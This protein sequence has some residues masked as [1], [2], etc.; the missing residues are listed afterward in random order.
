MKRTMLILPAAL[1]LFSALPQAAG[2]E[3]PKPLTVS[4]GE[5]I[6]I[7]YT[8]KLED[9]S[10]V[11]TNVGGMPLKYVQGGNELIPALELALEGLKVGDTKKVVLEPKDGYGEIDPKAFQ[12]V[13][14]SRIPPEALVVGT[15]L[16]GQDPTGDPIHVRVHEIKDSTVVLDLNHP[17][18]GK[19]LFFDV[20]IL[21]IQLPA[22]KEGGDPPKP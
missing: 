21:D 20:K 9:K 15:P 22:K 8:L 14:K 16:E 5:E 13:D 11:D 1:A 10:T 7:E 6:T 2:A 3:S 12:E 17:L 18:A 4:A 19:K